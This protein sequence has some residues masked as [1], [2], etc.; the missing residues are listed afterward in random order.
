[1]F[2]W[3]AEH[4]IQLVAEGT[5]DVINMQGFGHEIKPWIERHLNLMMK[6]KVIYSKNHVIPIHQTI[7]EM[8][9]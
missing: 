1:M 4:S 5:G 8:F 7:T 6:G 9:L 2:S 3:C